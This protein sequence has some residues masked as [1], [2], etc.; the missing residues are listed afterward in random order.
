MRVSADIGMMQNTEG[1]TL[2]CAVD[3]SCIVITTERILAHFNRVMVAPDPVQY[4][5]SGEIWDGMELTVS[6]I[7]S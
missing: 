7:G 5:Y 1:D 6:Y 3:A 2:Y 4:A